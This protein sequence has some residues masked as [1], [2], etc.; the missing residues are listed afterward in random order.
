MKDQKVQAFIG[1]SSTFD[2]LKLIP[3]KYLR[4]LP[5]LSDSDI[6]DVT[7]GYEDILEK[8]YIKKKPPANLY[9]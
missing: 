2:N 9:E 1:G 6:D 8:E 5:G 4:S 3:K 7:S